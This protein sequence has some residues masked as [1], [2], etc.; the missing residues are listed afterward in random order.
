[1]ERRVVTFLHPSEVDD[2]DCKSTLSR[3]PHQLFHFN[4]Q[5]NDGGLT[6]TTPTSFSIAP[7]CSPPEQ[8]PSP[9]VST[10]ATYL[11]NQTT[12][13]KTAALK[14]TPKIRKTHQINT[15]IS[16]KTR[17]TRNIIPFQQCSIQFSIN[18][19]PPRLHI[20]QFLTIL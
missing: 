8:C 13:K 3:S 19:T 15:I 11:V 1:M 9:H 20:S 6:E 14:H 4:V 16:L 10:A 5:L 2:A 7:P 12:Q 17:A 18:R